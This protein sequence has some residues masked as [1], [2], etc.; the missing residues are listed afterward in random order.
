MS[1]YSAYLYVSYKRA[2]A[3]GVSD[4]VPADVS[5]RYNT[6]APDFD[7]SVNLM[8]AL[9]GMNKLRRQLAQQATGD[10][11]EVSIGTGRNLTFYDWD[12]SGVNGVGRV[13]SDHRI[14]RGKVKSFTAV[15]KS[16]EM[17]GI[18]HD[19]FF[20]EYPGILGIRWVIQDASDPL[21]TPP[22]SANERGGNKRGKKYDTIVQTMGLCSTPDPVGLLKNLGR[23]LEDED[24]RI[25]LLEH[26]RGTWN[27]IN[28]MLDNL[29]PQHAAHFG[30]WWNKDI[31]KIVEQSGLEVV[32]IKRKHLGTT[33]WIELRPGKS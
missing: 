14:K 5:D 12:F 31:G 30:C 8:E 24:S 29:A 2:V 28:T 17:L 32:T 22:K 7:S 4:S 16:P 27:F 20:K 21:P 19:K 9:M 23:S 11:C 1:S 26:G 18:A 13:G 6:I 3:A 33:W 15:D 25:L 10:V